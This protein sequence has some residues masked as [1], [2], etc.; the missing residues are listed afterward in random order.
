ME[1]NWTRKYGDDSDQF[2]TSSYHRIL[3]SKMKK[4]KKSCKRHCLSSVIKCGPLEYSPRQHI[5]H[6]TVCTQMPGLW[7]SVSWLACAVGVAQ[8]AGLDL[9]FTMTGY[10]FC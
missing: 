1:G 6:V 5:F 4:K 8:V 9:V 3:N 2:I 10:A 7:E